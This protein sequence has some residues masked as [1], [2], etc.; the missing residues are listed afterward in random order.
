MNKAL[1]AVQALVALAFVGAAGMKL[2][3]PLDALAAK[4]AW[5]AHVPPWS[6]KVIGALELLGALGLILP[7]A[8]RI[9]PVLTPLAAAGLVLTMVAAAGLH[10]AI[11]EAAMIAPNIV[12][13]GL[14]AFIAWGR[15]SK[16][17]IA[18]K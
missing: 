17:P 11:G 1:W 9:K 14:C 10:I 8:L 15:H 13:G 5:V 2:S 3:T 7:S 16:A 12:L 6:V 4:M 18:P